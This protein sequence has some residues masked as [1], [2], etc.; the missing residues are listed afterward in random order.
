MIVR[1]FLCLAS[2][3]ASALADEPAAYDEHMAAARAAFVAED[4][5]GLAT[6][7]EGAQAYR[8]YSLYLTKN[9]VLAY[10][11]SGERA[12]AL[13]VVRK[14]A[15]RGLTM[16]LSGHEGFDA[17]KSDP[18]FAEIDALMKANA[19]PFGDPF[20]IEITGKSGMLPEAITESNDESLF[21][22]GVRNGDVIP[23]GSGPPVFSTNG[24]VFDI[25]LRGETLW[26]AVNNQL[27]FEREADAAPFASIAAFEIESGE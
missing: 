4:W 27:A 7:L 17:L 3:F 24:G 11:M 1:I 22:G 6:A 5:P 16:S 8:P 10:E 21:I 13:A 14:I 9:R 26:A 19:E 18:A 23:L 15:D 12:K 2:L 25:E 20:L